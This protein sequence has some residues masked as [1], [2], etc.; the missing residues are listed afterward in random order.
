MSAVATPAL[1]VVLA[2]DRFATV[3]PVIAALGRQ[4][5]PERIELVLVAPPHGLDDVDLRQVA[6][7]GGVTRVEVPGPLDLAAAR[8]AGVRA[9]AAP[10]VF[11]GET[12]TY[13]RPAWM[14]ALL[15]AFDGGWAVVVPEIGNAN[16][17]GPVSWASY[18]S[19]YANWGPGRR[20]GEIHDPLV[21]NTAYRRDVLLALGDRLAEA[22]EPLAELLRTMLVE[23]GYR[24]WFEPAAKIDHL[25]VAR[26]VDMLRENFFEGLLVA[27]SRARRWSWR[28]RLAYFLA[29]PLV[30]V[31]LVWR[32]MGLW[33]RTDVAVGLPSG[34][35]P[36]IVV[37]AVVKGVGEALGCLVGAPRMAVTGMHEIE[38]HKVR[39]AGRVRA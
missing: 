23:R 18:L 28:R 31:V 15:R 11:I 14:E 19:D 36:L 9:A 34:T 35:L 21:Y 10:L 16:P 25:N 26:F 3:R 30:P 38:V 5:A 27:D 20:A 39:F 6:P 2:T 37:A 8:A 12:H 29:S 7:F 32:V 4:A 33:R 1:S 13:V 22:L 24:V 17:T